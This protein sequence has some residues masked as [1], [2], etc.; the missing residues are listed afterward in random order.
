M[1]N[2]FCLVV[3]T[4]TALFTEVYGKSTEDESRIFKYEMW[5]VHQGQSQ[6]VPRLRCLF[7]KSDVYH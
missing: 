7:L 6:K 1:M 4:F 2:G 5:A 3:F